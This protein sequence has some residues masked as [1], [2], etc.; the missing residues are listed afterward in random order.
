MYRGQGLGLADDGITQQPEQ[1]RLVTE[2]AIA[3]LEAR[4]P[5]CSALRRNSMTGMSEVSGIHALQ[6]RR[7][8]RPQPTCVENVVIWRSTAHVACLQRQRCTTRYVQQTR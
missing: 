1:L 8:D 2:E 6:L 5:Y 3:R 7:T 4:Q